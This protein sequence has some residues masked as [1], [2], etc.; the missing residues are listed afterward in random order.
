MVLELIKKIWN[1]KGESRHHD[2][3]WLGKT[4][5][6]RTETIVIGHRI[7]DT[8]DVNYY[9]LIKNFNPGYML[10]AFYFSSILIA[11]LVY[12]VLIKTQKKSNRSY[13]LIIFNFIFIRKHLLS[14]IGISF[15]FF[16]LFIMLTQMM[17]SINVKTNKVVVDTSD[18]IRNR[19]D[20][21]K[22]RRG[23]C[24]STRHLLS[25]SV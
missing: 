15:I 25:D 13:L 7:F 20:A 2:E 6:M 8:N 22:S 1:S 4:L 10:L 17:L 18:L 23:M 14:S 24:V 19:Y 21:L 11:F 9:D 16:E 5:P 3:S 12:Q